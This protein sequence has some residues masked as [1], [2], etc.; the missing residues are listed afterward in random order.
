MEQAAK[1]KPN[2]SSQSAPK[3]KFPA[4]NIPDI[5]GYRFIQK[6]GHGSQ[7]QVYLAERLSDGLEVAIKKLNIDSV[8]NWKEYE[9]F[10][11]EAETLASLNI[12][13]VAHF[14]EAIER[15]EDTPP[16][17]YLVQEYIDGKSLNDMLKSGHRFSY[18]DV[19]DI[20]LQLTSIL[21]ELHTHEPPVIHRDIK[22]SNILLKQDPEGF[23]VYLID[24]GAVANPQVQSGGS[25]V[26]GTY[27]YMPPEQL[28][29]KPEPA[30]DIYSL[31]AVAVYLISG[32]SPADMPIKDFHLIFEPDM[33]NMPPAVVNTLRS[34]LEPDPEKRLCDYETIY[35]L[36]ENFQNDIFATT[37]S[38]QKVMTPSEFNEALEK[39]QYYGQNGNI[40]LWQE[41][42]DL[43]P[44][45]DRLIPALY[46]D[47][48]PVRS[49]QINSDGISV[50]DV[51]SFQKIGTPVKKKL[52]KLPIIIF[53]SVISV[54]ILLCIYVFE[55]PSIY[56]T[57]GTVIGIV[58]LIFVTLIRMIDP[59]NT[60]YLVGMPLGKFYRIRDTSSRH[61]SNTP[62]NKNSLNELMKNGRKTIATIVSVQYIKV[63]PK[64]IE[65]NLEV[66]SPKNVT[67]ASHLGPAFRIGYKFNPPDDLRSED[68]IHYIITFTEPE[69]H[70]K[71]NDPFPILYRLYKSVEESGK[72]SE[73]VESM[74][75]PLPPSDIYSFE[76]IMY[77]D[78]CFDSYT[79]ITGR[80]KESEDNVEYGPR[81]KIAHRWVSM[82]K[83][84]DQK[85]WFWN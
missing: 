8:K 77:N 41:L 2:Q 83:N 36:F 45:E 52:S 58:L 3:Q 66:T 24:F 69:N 39:V 7:G 5:P 14:Y 38:R 20:L 23:R 84:K 85:H 81:K 53:L 48:T 47:L 72:V 57:L 4:V 42:S 65:K 43:L 64:Y 31:A 60:H 11:R 26:A 35:D 12:E 63:N 79:Q 25:T 28:M 1:A 19:Y 62:L 16:C 71:V 30:S 76:N 10:H 74:P 27:G 6:L 50:F 78:Q 21:H 59:A 37:G 13:G 70:Y 33:Q 56:V 15:L 40:E 46:K 73:N 68:L 55:I 17:S 51:S 9:L 54:I 29:G 22:P 75:F 80:K 67:Y 34:M 49:D 32:R 82:R 61:V 18:V 44:R